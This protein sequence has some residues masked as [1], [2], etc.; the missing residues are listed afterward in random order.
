[1]ILIDLK[2]A[3]DAVCHKLLIKKLDHYRIRGVA[4][5]LISSYLH[6]RKQYVSLNGVNSEEKSIDMGV[7]QGSIYGP[8]LYV[9]YVNDLPNAID[10]TAR[11]YVYADDTCLIVHDYKS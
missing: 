10:C 7:P 11:L 2:K 5:N 6:N 8:L 9:M 1:M 4:N 3:F